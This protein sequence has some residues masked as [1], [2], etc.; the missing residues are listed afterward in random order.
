MQQVRRRKGRWSITPPQLIIILMVT[1]SFVLFYYNVLWST[2]GYQ[3]RKS[4]VQ[5]YE[6][7]QNGNYGSAWELFH[8]NMHEKFSKE[9]YIQKRAEVFMQQLGASTFEFE[10]NKSKNVGTWGMSAAS[11]ALSNVQRVHVTQHMLTVFG[12]LELDQEIFV[13]E[14]NDEWRLLFS[15]LEHES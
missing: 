15:Y 3:A 1:L 9:V 8:S 12:E 10:V 14:E 4:V 13:V 7:E 2:D 6:F 11:P 5:F